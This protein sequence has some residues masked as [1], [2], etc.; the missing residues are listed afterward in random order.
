[1]NFLIKLS[2]LFASR[3]KRHFMVRF[4]QNQSKIWDME[5]RQTHLREIKE[6]IRREYDRLNEHS[7]QLNLRLEAAK[8]DNNTE[9][10]EQIK[11][12]IEGITGDIDKMAKQ[13]EGLDNEINGDSNNSCRTQLEALNAVRQMFKK[14]MRQL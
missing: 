10:V 2:W 3:K 12:D 13:M 4:W 9:E 11:K 5:F 7:S 1:M 6:G 14:Y 8:Q